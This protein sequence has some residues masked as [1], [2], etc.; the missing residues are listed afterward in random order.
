MLTL[1]AAV[2]ADSRAH[3]S[4]DLGGSKGVTEKILML[5]MEHLASESTCAGDIAL[6][7]A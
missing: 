2:C 5:G 3:H 6:T 1:P 7:N 4:K